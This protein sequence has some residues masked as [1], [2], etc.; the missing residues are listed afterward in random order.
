MV[1]LP[2]DDLVLLID[3]GLVCLS[4]GPH[5]CSL[6]VDAADVAQDHFHLMFSG[7]H[8][9]SIHG[10]SLCK[11]GE[12]LKLRTGRYIS[13]NGC[14]S[15]QPGHRCSAWIMPQPLKLE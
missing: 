3:P 7:V 15:P 10:E 4:A 2:D 13:S 11:D 14:S 8:T 6:V 5:T 1:E 12:H 9:G